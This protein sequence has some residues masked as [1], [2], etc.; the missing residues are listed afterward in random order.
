MKKK[1]EYPVPMVAM[2]GKIE[3]DP[4]GSYT[5]RAEDPYEIPV[6]DADDL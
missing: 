5:G 1:I 2:D 6:Q 4:L 3:V